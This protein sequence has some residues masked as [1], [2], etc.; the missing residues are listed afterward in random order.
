MYSKSD[1]MEMVFYENRLYI[2]NDYN[3]KSIFYFQLI[4]K[5]SKNLMLINSEFI[6]EYNVFKYL[7]VT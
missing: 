1:L 4:T 2:R 3:R 7:P 6:K 5:T